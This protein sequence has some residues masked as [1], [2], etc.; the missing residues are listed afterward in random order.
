MR[1]FSFYEQVGIIL[2]GVVLVVGLS[3]I[4]PELRPY[5]PTPETDLGALGILLVVAYAAGHL[6]AGVGNFVERVFWFPFGGMPSNWVIGAK[7]RLLTSA[8]IQTL[9]TRLKSRCSLDVDLA[10]IGQADWDKCFQQL[11]RD[12]LVNAPGR[13]EVFN[14]NYGLNRGLA[15]A[16]LVVLAVALAKC[17]LD[18]QTGLIVGAMTALMLYRMHRFGRHFARE[19]LLGFL[20]LLDQK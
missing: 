15:S 20:N 18:L 9:R 3:L 7:P 6:V 14:G 12:A 2:P 11:Y 8:Q 1:D 13:I 10:T 19:V 17:A 16:L 4:I 5:A